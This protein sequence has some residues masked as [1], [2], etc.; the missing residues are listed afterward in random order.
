M[1]SGCYHCIEFRDLSRS[2]G[3]L[4][5]FM[6]IIVIITIVAYLSWPEQ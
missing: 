2:V 1:C 3:A 4:K 5:S 6:I